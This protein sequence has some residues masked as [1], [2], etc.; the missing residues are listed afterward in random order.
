ML[1]G[2]AQERSQGELPGEGEMKTMKR[3]N[4]KKKKKR[5]NQKK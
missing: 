1:L 5:K 2:E 4:R 3:K